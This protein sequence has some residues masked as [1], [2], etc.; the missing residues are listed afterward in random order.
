MDDRGKWLSIVSRIMSENIR[1][2]GPRL[3]G[4]WTRRKLIC[5]W[6]GLVIIVSAYEYALR[7]NMRMILTSKNL[8]CAW[9]DALDHVTPFH[10]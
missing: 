7:P 8:M 3:C 6:G 9:C 1:M 4:A 2:L 5:S 10:G